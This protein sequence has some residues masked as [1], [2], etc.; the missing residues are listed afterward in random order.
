MGAIACFYIL[1]VQQSKNS[2]NEAN[3]SENPE[4]PVPLKWRGNEEI[5]I[6]REYLR[7]ATV[8]PDIN[9]SKNSA[10]RQ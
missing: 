6:F 3:Q 8:H 4:K 9:Y 1:H 2:Q 7:I 10:D 5:K